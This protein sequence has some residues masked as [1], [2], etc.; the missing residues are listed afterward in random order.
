MSCIDLNSMSSER[1]LAHALTQGEP[2]WSEGDV[3]LLRLDLRDV[4]GGPR[5]LARQGPV[6]HHLQCAG[7]GLQAC[8]STARSDE[9]SLQV[10][11]RR[12]SGALSKVLWVERA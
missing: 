1:R 10:A 3:E 9:L 8:G 7:G 5:R 4:L 12:A 11:P 2:T 6:L